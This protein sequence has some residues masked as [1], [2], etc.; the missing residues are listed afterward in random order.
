[1][2]SII[3]AVDKNMLIGKGNELPWHFSEDLQYFK[4]KTYGKYIVMGEKT[5]HSI[6]KPL[7]GRKVV[8]LSDNEDFKPEG[9]T[10]VSSIKEALSVTEGEVFIAGG[11]SVYEQFMETADRIYL[12]EIQEVFEGDVYFPSIDKSVWKTVSEERGENAS[13]VFKVLERR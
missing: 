12:T 4:K 7:P 13:L 2:I 3:V 6:G 9:V 10:V 5:F 8:V 11:K 1:M